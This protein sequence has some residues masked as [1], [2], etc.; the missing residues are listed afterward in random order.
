MSRKPAEFANWPWSLSVAF[1]PF[2]A[3]VRHHVDGDTFD[4]LIDMGWNSYQ[5]GPVRLL[6]M[7]TP[8]TNRLATRALGLAAKQFVIGV[9]PVGARVVLH[10]TRP[11]PDSFGRYLARIR[12]EDGRDVSTLLVESGHA[13]RTSDRSPTREGTGP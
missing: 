1:G 7:D 6:G 13:V 4:C 12:L 3:V 10:D 9:M 8:E 11:D 2:R 5:Y